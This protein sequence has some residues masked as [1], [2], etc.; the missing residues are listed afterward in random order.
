MC[1][2]YR[3]S[4]Y[5]SQ[6]TIFTVVER[7]EGRQTTLRMHRDVSYGG[8]C[9]RDWRG[10]GEGGLSSTGWLVIREERGVDIDE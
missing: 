2:Y 7:D 4:R 1:L 10:G 6:G 9:R 3:C 8:R 5:K